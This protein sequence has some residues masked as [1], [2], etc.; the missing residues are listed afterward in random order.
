MKRRAL[1]PVEFALLVLCFL[2]GCTEGPEDDPSPWEISGVELGLRD[3]D[4]RDLVPGCASDDCFRTL[5]AVE[6]TSTASVDFLEGEDWIVA[7][8]VDGVMRA[9]PLALLWWHQGLHDEVAGHPIFATHSSLTGSTLVFRA[10]HRGEIRQFGVSKR[11]YNSSTVF[12]YREDGSDDQVLLP[13]L[14]TASVTGA[15]PPKT[16]PR[17]TAR[18]MTWA[19]WQILHPGG[20]VATLETGYNIDYNLDPFAS[21]RLDH[22]LILSPLSEPPDSRFPLKERTLLVRSGREYRAYPSSTLAG[23]GG[24]L[25]QVLNGVAFA[26]EMNE[27][28]EF[29]VASAS[30]TADLESYVAF[31]FA[32][33]AF[34]PGVE[35]FEPMP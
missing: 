26:V 3:V 4:L 31:W 12:Y 5:T 35:V 22:D 28:G 29:T 30:V 11:F 8:E 16:W 10:S 18:E 17:I 9:Y 6:V 19:T 33:A 14:Y 25:E 21:Y 24:P 13:Q 27:T 20:S 23:Q 7:V 34:H 15:D 32:C 2:A 1:H